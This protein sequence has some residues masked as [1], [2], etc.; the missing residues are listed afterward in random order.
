MKDVVFNID[1]N[2][3]ILQGVFEM[4]I[5]STDELPEIHCG[6]FIHMQVPNRNDLILRRPI[7]VCKYDSKSI[8]IIYAVVGKGTSG[9]AKMNKGEKISAIVPLGNGFKLEDKHKKVVLIG[10]GIGTAPL[11]SVKK[12][13]PDRK[14]YTYLGFTTKNSIILEKDFKEISNEFNIFTDDGSYGIKGYPTD[15]LDA[16]IEKFKPDVILTCG[17]EAL[18]K[19]V[20]K[21]SKNHNVPA[22]MTGESRMGCGVGACLVCTCQIRQA[23]GSIENKR[24]CVDGPI[25]SL[26][27]LVL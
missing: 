3:E 10:G 21:V 11:L 17:S 2:N 15:N 12:S 23:D 22:Y 19:S 5:S 26:E 1:Y 6:Q 4:K 20:A 7:C 14:I 8:T 27:D 25:F 24:A 16:E 13:Y 18:L 9:L